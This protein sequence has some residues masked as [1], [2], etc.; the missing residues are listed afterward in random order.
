M[1][2]QQYILQVS[3]EAPECTLG[4]ALENRSREAKAGVVR[5]GLEVGEATHSVARGA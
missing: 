1:H 5:G 3:V 2:A 4:K